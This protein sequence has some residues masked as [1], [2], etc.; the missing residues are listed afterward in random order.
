MSGIRTRSS[1]SPPAAD[2]SSL[3]GYRGFVH[4]DGYDG[5]NAVHDDVRHLGCWM[6]ARRYFVEAERL[7]A[8][9]N[10]MSPT[11][12]DSKVA[13]LHARMTELACADWVHPDAA[14]LA[15]RLLKDGESLLTFAEFPEVPPTNNAAERE[16]RPAVVMRKV[17]YGSASAQG[18]A[19]RA[20]PMSVF[21]TL[22]KRGLDP[23]A[24]IRQ[25]LETLGKTGQL[26]PLPHRIGSAG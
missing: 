16:I 6:H 23:L 14:R 17:S 1:I 4:A 20:I 22:K 25:A 26:P 19:T 2:T 21:R 3:G 9:D 5:Y 8:A 13:R 7:A 11:E 18:A 15:K 10:P 12:R 24:E